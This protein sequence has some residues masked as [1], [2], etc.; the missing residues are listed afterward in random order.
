MTI[1]KFGSRTLLSIAAA[2]LMLV[3]VFDLVVHRMR[4][5]A[6]SH[7][8]A[9]ERLKYYTTDQRR[10]FTFVSR[11]TLSNE[12]LDRTIRMEVTEADDSGG[13]SVYARRQFI[14]ASDTAPTIEAAHRIERPAGTFTAFYWS[15]WQE[16]LGKPMLVTYGTNKR[17]IHE[18]TLSQNNCT[19]PE[20]SLAFLRN[21]AVT[22]DG[23]DYPAAVVRSTDETMTITTWHS[24]TPGLGCLE[25]KSV[26]SYITPEQHRGI[27][28]HEPVSLLLED[29]DPQLFNIETRISGSE[30]G[31]IPAE[32]V[33]LDR[34]EDIVKSRTKEYEKT[35]AGHH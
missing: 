9:Y 6:Q 30:A 35:W 22:I 33:S 12:D 11:Y 2:A 18:H 21:E 28:V 32:V 1:G 19:S 31:L 10:P 7:A 27:T 16:A 17:L 25:L 5:Q 20:P 13:R 34:W 3:I 8:P 14:P 24:T 26:T 4:V 15:K 29:P 23:K